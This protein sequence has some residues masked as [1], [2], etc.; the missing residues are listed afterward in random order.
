[1]DKFS[2]ISAG[3]FS[4]AGMCAVRTDHHIYKIKYYNFPMNI[5]FR[6]S[7]WQVVNGSLK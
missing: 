2:L 4:T 7:L 6:S 5:C 3:L 1:M